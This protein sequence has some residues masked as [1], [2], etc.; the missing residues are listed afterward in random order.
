M[1]A[2]VVM[3][4]LG[5]SMET[6][7]VVTWH[8]REGDKV[9]KGDVL[10][11]V[12]TDKITTDVEAPQDGVLLKLLVPEGSEVKVQTLLAVIGEPGEDISSF[13]GPGLPKAP[14]A[15]GQASAEAPR[16]TPRARKMLADK[17][18]SPSE[19]AGSGKA[20][21]TE[22]DVLE[23]IEK[24]GTVAERGQKGQTRPM[25]RVEKLTAARMTESFRDIPQ[26]SV[27]FTSEVDRFDDLR[28]GTS[29]SYNDLILRAVA[30]ALA[31]Y[32]DVQC[33]Y[34]PDGIFSPADINIGFAVAV[35][36]DL[37]VPVI[38]NA[39][40]KSCRQIAEESS[41]L[42]ARAKEHKLLPDDLTGGTFTVSNLGMFGITSFTPIVNPG[43]GS[44]LGAGAVQEA[45]R[46]R[47][48]K[49]VSAK[50]VELTLVCDHRA[51]N[52]A[53]AAEFC[54]VFRDVIASAETSSW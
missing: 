40:R 8:A 43:E 46:L 45:P 15:P 54:K 47:N 27:R 10:L 19:L 9:R 44:I 53:T 37:V 14:Q 26:F 50:V 52:G 25:S 34:R 42:I 4:K 3:P 36:K 6:G 30:M 23:L 38:R 29:V 49:L 2:P 12:E 5:L 24:R 31:R 33:Q 1:A 48:G 51:V 39:D 35:G 7:T 11:V 32:P 21:I 18:I 22:A 17:G 13:L 20:R 41:S 28:A 16:I